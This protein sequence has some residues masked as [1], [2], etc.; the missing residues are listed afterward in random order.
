MIDLKVIKKSGSSWS[1]PILLVKKKTELWLCVDF[2]KVNLVT[3]KDAYPTPWFL[4]LQKHSDPTK[5]VINLQGY[6][7][8]CFLLFST[9][10]LSKRGKH[11]HS[12]L[13]R[14]T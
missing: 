5:K 14:L 6:P 4:N 2:R 3:K 7:L 10:R 13:V 12:C 1:S 9:A 11:C 8:S